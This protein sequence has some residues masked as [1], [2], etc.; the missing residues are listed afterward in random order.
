MEEPK[1]DIKTY[2][3]YGIVIGL[4]ALGVY[5]FFSKSITDTPPPDETEE[6]VAESVEVGENTLMPDASGL[7]TEDVKVG[8]GDE[9]A[10]GKSVT[11]HYVGTLQDGTKFDSSRDR[12]EPFTFNLGAGEVI[13]GW[14]YGVAGM[15]VGGVRKLTIPPKLAY[16]EY[17]APPTIGPNE[18]LLF[19]V[20]LLEVN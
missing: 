7:K 17:G 15:K 16:G 1:R 18:T 14:D 2:L 10:P 3:M 20:E 6:T 4:L 9:A 5:Y 8:S 11:V 12:G 19:E 13:P